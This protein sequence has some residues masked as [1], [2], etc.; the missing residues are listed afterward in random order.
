MWVNLVIAIAYALF[1]WTHSSNCILKVRFRYASYLKRWESLFD[2]RKFPFN[3]FDMWNIRW[4]ISLL[5][6]AF[7]VFLRCRRRL[8]FGRLRCVAIRS[9]LFFYSIC[10]LYFQTLFHSPVYF[11]FFFFFSLEG[12]WLL[13]KLTCSSVLFLCEFLL[14]SV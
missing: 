6:L 1:E 8:F 11:N 7:W 10:F 5:L 9:F 3:L 4:E 13:L 12:R 14:E 2:V